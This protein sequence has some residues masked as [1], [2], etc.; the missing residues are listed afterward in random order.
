MKAFGK[1]LATSRKNQNYT[2][3]EVGLKLGIDAA[4]LSKIERGLRKATR[5]QVSVLANFYGITHKAAFTTWLSDKILYELQGEPF[6]Q[7][8]F[9]VAEEALKYETANNANVIKSESLKNDLQAIDA[10]HQNWKSKKPLNATQ[11]LKMQEYF[12]VAYT[13]NS[14]LIEGNTLTMQETHLVVNEGLT[15]SGKSVKEHLEAVNHYEAIDFIY[16]LVQNKEPL[17]ERVLKEIHY[18]ILKSIDRVNAGVYRKVPVIISGSSHKPPQ[19]YLL[20]KQ[21]E[22]VFIYY[23][24]VRGKIH[25]VLLAAQ[26]HQ[27]I[28]TIHPFIDGN[29]RTCRL[30]MNL[31]LLQN[32]YTIANLKGDN[33]SRKEYYEALE[34]AHQP[35]KQEVFNSLIVKT[36]IQSLEDHLELAG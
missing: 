34:L 6:A 10:L 27:K 23:N 21:M 8:A 25:P 9:A 15:I 28:V 24:S 32:G 30:I 13:F 14:N 3:S 1:L 12:N 20:N 29:G 11:L 33:T 4:I 19:P 35:N 31:I 36:A 7:E 5:A 22:D 17:T 2:L 16:E 26:M 18:L